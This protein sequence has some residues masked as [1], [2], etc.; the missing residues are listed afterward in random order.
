[1]AEIADSSPLPR[2]AFHGLALPAHA[3]GSAAPG[4]TARECVDLTMFFVA[5]RTGRAAALQE[6]VRAGLGLALPSTPARSAAGDLS[7]L[8]I[9]PD[10]WLVSFHQDRSPDAERGLAAACS[11]QAGMVEVGDGRAVLRVSGPKARDVLAK[12]VPIDLHP[13]VFQPG[14]AASTVAA[15]I[16]I[17]LAQ[18]DEDPTYEI[19]LFRSLA[20]SFW[21]WLESSSAEFGLAVTEP[22]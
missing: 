14:H 1:M 13:S 15:M 22:L 20:G 17:H 7:A 16:D 9:G 8:W 10:Q 12:G 3:S 19:V 4:V 2:S 6:A 21:H 11:Q 18:I 5:A